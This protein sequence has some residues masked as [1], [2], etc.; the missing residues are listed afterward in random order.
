M[1]GPDTM[2]GSETRTRKLNPAWILGMKSEGYAGRSR[3]PIT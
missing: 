2:L 3:C 1:T